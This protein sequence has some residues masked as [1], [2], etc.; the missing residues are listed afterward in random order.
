MLFTGDA[1]AETE[2]RML[3]ARDDLRADILKV[4]HHGSAYGTTPAFVRAVAPHIAIV[5]VGRNNLFGHPSPATIATLR[6]AG[7]TVFR[8]DRD[9]AVIVATDGRRFEAT[10][11]LAPDP[12]PAVADASQ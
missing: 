6:A 10:S 11:F 9:G 7:A 2:A 4:G 1:G 12:S 8:T 5:S 3:A